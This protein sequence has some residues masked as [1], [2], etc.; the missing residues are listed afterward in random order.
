MTRAV[1]DHS[2]EQLRKDVDFI[3]K[4]LNIEVVEQET[5]TG[6]VKSESVCNEDCYE[7]LED[8][9]VYSRASEADEDCISQGNVFHD[10]ASAERESLARKVK[11]RLYQCFGNDVQITGGYDVSE[12][13]EDVFF[14]KYDSIARG[15]VKG[16]IDNLTKEELES[17]QNA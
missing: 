5:P 16:F 9:S 3:L 1:I 13:Y 8:G 4:C 7:V 12:Y 11:H 2:V 15:E 10:K 17:I 6:R 14:I